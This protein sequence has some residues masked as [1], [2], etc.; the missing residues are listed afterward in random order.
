MIAGS[1][2][3]SEKI[4]ELAEL[5]SEADPGQTELLERLCLAAERELTGRL[6]DGVAPEDCEPAF[7]AGAAWL[8]LAGLYGGQ[9][10]E[11]VE[12]FTAGELTVRPTGGE[13]RSARLRAQA[14][15]VMAPYLRDG[16]F[17]FVGVRG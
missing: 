3:L 17:A 12:A 11:E 14:E 15:R 4:L 8:A 1:G 9:G 6:R 10:T 16:G 5:L 13:A 2:S 7:V